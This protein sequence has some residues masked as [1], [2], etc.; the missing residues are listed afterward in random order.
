MDNNGSG[1][2]DACPEPELDPPSLLLMLPLL[3][4]LVWILLDIFYS[5]A[6]FGWAVTRLPTLFLTDSAIHLGEL[7]DLQLK[8]GQSSQSRISELVFS[9]LSNMTRL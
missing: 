4:S 7:R 9:L 6:L 5:S 1:S 3:L 2:G 8:V